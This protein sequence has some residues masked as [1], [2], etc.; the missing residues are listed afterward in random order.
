MKSSD[1]GGREGLAAASEAIERGIAEIG[2]GRVLKNAETWIPKGASS[3]KERIVLVAGSPQFLL[4]NTDFGWGKPRK[5]EM[6]SVDSTRGIW[7]GDGRNGDGGIEVGLALS[8]LE[9][10]RFASAFEDGLASLVSL[11]TSCLS[12]SSFHA[13]R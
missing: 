12:G 6:V 3:L 11:P 10:D 8:K 13:C 2:E 1:L 5:V 7:L 4:Y 9:M